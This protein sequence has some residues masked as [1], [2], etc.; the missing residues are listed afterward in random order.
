MHNS[1][2]RGQAIFVGHGSPMNALAK[3]EYTQSLQNWGKTLPH[4]DA[5]LMISAHWMTQGTFVSCQPHPRQIYDFYGFPDELYQIKYPC[6]GDP[7]LAEKT[8]KCL[9]T[10]FQ[11]AGE[12]PKTRDLAAGGCSEA[13][14][15]D[16]GAWTVLM[17]LFPQADIPVVPL[18]LDMSK[19]PAYHYLLGQALRSLRTK[20][21]MVIA[22]GNITHNLALISQEED[23]PVPHWA[24]DMDEKIKTLLLARDHD[25]LVGYPHAGLHASQGIPT[26]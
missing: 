26:Q 20:K 8:V 15:I 3:N 16:H 1:L 13:W 19:P 4:P 25:A 12:K 7:G 14:G 6:P 22:S 5:I 17:H 23:A 11:T 9:H 24:R 10:F 18:S 21:V 2:Q